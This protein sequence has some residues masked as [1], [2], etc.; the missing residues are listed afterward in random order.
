MTDN[1]IDIIKFSV[2]ALIVFATVY[3]LFNNFLQ[4]QYQLEL[5]RH[6]QNAGKDLLPLK[7][8]A[9]ERLVMV[10]ERISVDNLAF[11]LSNS[12]MGV[13]ELKNAMLIAI[14]QEYEHN[15]TQ[16]VY[17]SENLWKIVKLAKDQMQDMISRTDGSTTAEFV[18]NFYRSLSES[19]ADPIAYAKTAIKKEV[20][21]IM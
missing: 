17:V 20:D 10:C 2:P 7:L 19:K 5:L 21:L 15:I 4:Q 8:Q 6:R 14:Q 11:R 16:Q 12:D 3:Y 9:Y 18:T 1:I 13:N